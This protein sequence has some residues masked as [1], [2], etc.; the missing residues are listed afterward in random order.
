MAYFNQNEN[1]FCKVIDEIN[2]VLDCLYDHNL[3][4]DGALTEDT[5]YEASSD[6]FS[7]TI[8]SHGDAF[9]TNVQYTLDIFGS[10]YEPVSG[11]KY[12]IIDYI[13]SEDWRG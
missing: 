13:E 2:E 11:D 5:G 4:E 3:W 8:D 7:L 10:P 1:E 9:E 6:K 12:D